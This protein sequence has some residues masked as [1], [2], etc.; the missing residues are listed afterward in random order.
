MLGISARGS[1]AAKTPQVRSQPAHHLLSRRVDASSSTRGRAY[2]FLPVCLQ[3]TEMKFARCA[4]ALIWLAM[5]SASAFAAPVT[6]HVAGTD[7]ASI[8]G[9]LV[10]VQNLRSNT[11]Q[12]LSRGLTG[13]GGNV[14][15]DNMEPGLYRA[16]ASDSYRSWKTEVEEFLV[17]SQPVTVTLRL[18][19][20]VTDDPVV[21]TVGRLTVHV[22]D[23]AGNAAV[24]ARVLLRDAE[25]HPHAEHWGTADAQGTVTLDVSASSSVLVIVYNGQLYKFPANS[26]DTERTIHL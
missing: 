7:G 20:Q 21:A 5:C 26:Y 15:L 2:H 8:K 25:A 17:K 16:I 24:G 1:D 11:E 23:S 9:A 12:E 10:I 14:T 4:F 6:I 22:L 19:R 13:E 3:H 18:E